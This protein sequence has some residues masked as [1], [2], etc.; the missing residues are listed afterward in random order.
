M[1]FSLLWWAVYLAV[2]AAAWLGTPGGHWPAGYSEV[3][4]WLAAG[5]RAAWFLLAPW[6]L[7]WA[8]VL[9][10]RWRAQQVLPVLTL[11]VAGTASVLV[12]WPAGALALGQ[13]AHLVWAL[14][15]FVAL[16][17]VAFVVWLFG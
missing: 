10:V 1:L 13:L 17:P 5:S 14:L 7:C 12:W 2:L 15:L 9:S 3:M 11:A 4:G 8:A 16:V 6:W